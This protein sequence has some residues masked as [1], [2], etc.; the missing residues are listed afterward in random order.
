MALSTS[1]TRYVLGWEQ[2]CNKIA[3]HHS[4]PNRSLNCFGTTIQQR[5]REDTHVSY[6]EDYDPSIHR[7]KFYVVCD[8]HGCAGSTVK[9]PNV[10]CFG[11]QR[12]STK[13]TMLPLHVMILQ[14]IAQANYEVDKVETA[15]CEAFVEMD[16]AVF[17]ECLPG[18]SCVVMIVVLDEQHV[19]A[20]HIGDSK[21]GIFDAA[22][23]GLLYE[24]QSHNVDHQDERI[25]VKQLGGFFSYGRL[26][27]VIMITR[28]IGDC[29]IGAS[30]AHGDDYPGD[31]KLVSPVP[32][33]QRID[34][35]PGQKLCAL[36]T[37]DAPYDTARSSRPKYSIESLFEKL[38]DEKGHETNFALHKFNRTHVCP[39]T[40]DDSTLLFIDCLTQ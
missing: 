20:A 14:N 26:S 12:G 13:T 9:I 25:R 23:A 35:K 15:I 31:T 34:V 40:S 2:E 6:P 10:I 4:R 7:L 28:A 38:R 32:H 22:T 16:R 19:F 8:G 1:E 29:D 5:A 3:S 18:G 36:L 30:S 21:I 11:M 33:V 37:S 39:F 27:G 24:S 17:D